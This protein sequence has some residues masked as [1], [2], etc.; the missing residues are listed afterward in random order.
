MKKSITTK[1]NAVAKVISAFVA[2]FALI[3]AAAIPASATGTST[4]TVA[5]F[6]ASDGGSSVGLISSA[7][8]AAGND[9]AG[10]RY[11]NGAYLVKF[12]SNGA[13]VWGKEFA[14]ITYSEVDGVAI[15][16]A[17]NIYTTGFFV[18]DLNVGGAWGVQSNPGFVNLFLMKMSS[19]G[20]VLAFSSWSTPSAIDYVFGSAIGLDRAGNVYVTAVSSNLDA[21]GATGIDGVHWSFQMNQAGDSDST[22]VF[23]FNS[24]FVLQ[25]ATV[26]PSGFYAGNGFQ[27]FA[28]SPSGKVL[29][30]GYL[31]DTTD[32]GSNGVFTAVN[33]DAVWMQLNT[34]GVIDRFNV[35]SGTGYGYIRGLAFDP[36]GNAYV[37]GSTSAAI[38][39]SNTLVPSL[40]ATT[41]WLAKYPIGAT[42]PAWVQ[43]WGSTGEL[44]GAALAVDAAGNAV[45]AANL[46]LGTVTVGS[47][48]TY[49][50]PGDEESFTLGINSDGTFAWFKGTQ[51]AS[52][53]F[54]YVRSLA[55]FGNMAV[56]VG[57]F[58]GSVDFGTGVQT[59]ASGSYGFEV[60]T[61]ISWANTTPLPLEQS[62]QQPAAQ[63]GTNVPQVGAVA[64]S[65]LDSRTG[66]D[67]TI[68]GS[69]MS[70]V[71]A[72][73]LA[74][75][76]LV[77]KIVNDSTLTVTLP[78]HA[79]G[80]ADLLIKTATGN[81]SFASAATYSDTV[82]THFAS[83]AVT[84]KSVG[85]IKSS[86]A[87]LTNVGYV[88]C[89]AGYGSN[90]AAAK[91]KA[92][93]KAKS[94]CAAAGSQAPDAVLTSTATYVK[95][96]T[97]SVSVTITGRA[98]N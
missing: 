76:Q 84:F 94:V 49:A 32:F 25:R 4:A 31:R 51:S 75:S 2:A 12:S 63:V 37:Y 96:S 70:K 47:F 67:I 60:R 13:R 88:D 33:Q 66:G 65:I 86:I 42:Q 29:I 48:P 40:G 98:K 7:V 23:K 28:V 16:S 1:G 85:Q 82:G 59:S 87:K 55:I 71:T 57:S 74:S 30:G 15:D 68:T 93:A 58:S 6:T 45:I 62:V 19:D 83:L 39:I 21:L 80:A 26:L 90:T 36:S 35:Y 95:G 50:P 73:L 9:Y 79:A 78:P 53:S 27:G 3:I 46:Y 5:S 38:T 52:N 11:A 69:G 8:D 64:G 77:F 22:I 89:Q 14:S 81:L 17:G 10:G 43:K 18:D 61:S 97:L 56:M 20:N 54:N 44:N 41:E 92:L 24:N 34:Q 72:V 91:G